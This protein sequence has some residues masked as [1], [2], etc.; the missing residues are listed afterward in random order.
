MLQNNLTTK[1]QKY[2][3]EGE[4]N[5]TPKVD[6]FHGMIFANGVLIGVTLDL[7]SIFSYEQF[8]EFQAQAKQELALMKIACQVKQAISVGTGATK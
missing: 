1:T 5:E 2:R 4:I 7:L 8:V 3:V 6:K